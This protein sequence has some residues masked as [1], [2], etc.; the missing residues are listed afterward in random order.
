MKK[1]LKEFREFAVQGN[2]IDMAVGMIIGAAFKDLVNSLVSDMVMPVIGLFTG[3]LDFSNMFISLNGEHYATLAEAQAAA[4]PTV[5]YG[6]FITEIINFV[7][8]AFVIFMVVK[9]LNRAKKYSINRRLRQQLRKKNARTAKRKSIFMRHAV[10]IVHR[11][12]KISSLFQT[13]TGR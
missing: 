5:N 3:K 6:L 8:M 1:I 4:A 11:F 7:I 2:M 10:R 9:Q 12:W 13:V